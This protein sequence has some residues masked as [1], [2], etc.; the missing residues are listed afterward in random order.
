MTTSARVIVP[1]A[2]VV[3]AVIV[4]AVFGFLQQ[5]TRV[6][7]RELLGECNV[8]WPPELPVNSSHRQQFAVLLMRPN[9]TARI[10][11]GY[12]SLTP[13]S[14]QLNLQTAVIPLGH[15]TAGVTL[16]AKPQNL[17]VPGNNNGLSPTG[18]AYAVFT[19]E[20][21]NDSKGFYI[22]KLPGFCPTIPFAVGY[23][24]AQ[25]NS[26][27]FSGWL[28]GNYACGSETSLLQGSYMSVSNVDVAYPYSY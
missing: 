17:T 12:S 6:Y 14:M 27:S 23:S 28:A 16:S 13:S 5:P 24:A 11:V 22:L 2:A 25:V 7:N 10:C 15:G 18:V 8:S 21:A 26:T 9:S 20:L 4:V 1:I 3:I 19:I